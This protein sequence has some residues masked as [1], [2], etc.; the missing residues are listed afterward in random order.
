MNPTIAERLHSLP[1]AVRSRLAES[2]E[3]L[4]DSPIYG[5]RGRGAVDLRQRPLE[6]RTNDDGTVEVHGYATTWNTEYDVAGGPPYGWVEEI[7]DGAATRSLAERDDVRFLFDHIGLPM[8]RTASGT[9]LLEADTL[10]LRVEVPNLDVRGNTDAANLAS[11][12]G[13]QDVDQMSFAFRAI[14][15]EWNDDYTHRRILEVRLFDVSAVSFPANPATIVALRSALRPSEQ[16]QQ[17]QQR[18][19]LSLAAAKR[20]A[21]LLDL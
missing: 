7:A 3:L 5:R 4:L 6:A 21:L 10:G 2:D 20:A 8:A 17:Q 9:L 15:Q 13:R 14:R 16:E 1:A 18:S 11:A 12:L 19:G